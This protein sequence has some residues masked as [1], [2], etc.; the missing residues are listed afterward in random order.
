MVWLIH[1]NPRANAALMHYAIEIALQSQKIESV[2][3]EIVEVIVVHPLAFKLETYCAEDPTGLAVDDDPL[4]FDVIVQAIFRGQ[5]IGVFVE[6][7]KESPRRAGRRRQRL[8]IPA[9]DL[10]AVEAIDKL[11]CGGK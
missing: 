3:A 9:Q 1:R 5:V 8:R 7:L 10:A 6:G 2:P 11:S 4:I